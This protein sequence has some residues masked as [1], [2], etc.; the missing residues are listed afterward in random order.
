METRVASRYARALFNTAKHGNILDAVQSDLHGI[1]DTL[2]RDARFKRFLLNPEVAREDK[3]TLLATVFSGRTTALTMQ[4]LRTLLQKD[5]QDLIE[6]VRSEFD[7]LKRD[8]DKV[9]KIKIET[10]RPLD[11][12]LRGA[13]VRKVE[14]ATSKTVQVEEEVIEGL[15]GGVRVRIGNFLMD[16]TVTGAL[17]KM[18]EKLQYDLL[19]Q[20]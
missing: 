5:R 11:A 9:V 8:H 7:A 16:G 1:A 15:L 13:I 10:A 2:T 19:K 12:A 20:S 17:G 4:A 14:T 18:R 3:M 6:V